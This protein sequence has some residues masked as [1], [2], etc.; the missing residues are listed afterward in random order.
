MHKDSIYKKIL[1]STE[2]RINT[3]YDYTEKGFSSKFFSNRMF[4]NPV[5]E[6][7]INQLDKWFILMMDGVRSIQYK[8]NYTEDKND[9]TINI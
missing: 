9:K 6:S 2:K 8:N 7:F 1:K 3:G 5:M 4:E